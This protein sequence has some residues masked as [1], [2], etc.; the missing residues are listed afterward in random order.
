MRRITVTLVAS[1]GLALA[2]CGGDDDG[3][4]GKSASAYASD[5]CTAAKDW[6]GAIQQRS[7]EVRGALQPGASPAEGKRVLRDFLDDTVTETEQFSQ[8]VRDAGTPDVE[9]GDAA[10]NALQ[11]A[12]DEAKGILENA[13]SQADRLPTDDREEF[14]RQAGTLGDSTRQSLSSVGDAFRTEQSSELRD[15]FNEADE[16]RGVTRGG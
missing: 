10:A 1:A 9:R 14:A 5:V 4:G 11:E 6:V 13:R 8:A 3:G 7:N 15:A 16:C 2:G 12:A